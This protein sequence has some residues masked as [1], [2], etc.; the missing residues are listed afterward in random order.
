MMEIHLFKDKI[1]TGNIGIVGGYRQVI[2]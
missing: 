2:R 1:S